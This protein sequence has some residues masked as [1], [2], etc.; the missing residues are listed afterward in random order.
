[1][2]N[3]MI[4]RR[5]SFPR[6]GLATFLITGGVVGFGIVLAQGGMTARVA[7]FLLAVGVLL[8][9]LWQFRARAA[10]RLQATWDAYAEREIARAERRKTP[11][12]IW[13]SPPRK[14]ELR[15]HRASRTGPSVA[16]EVH[17]S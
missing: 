4:G 14:A 12:N 11:A 9:I 8:G 2:E 17:E 16:N 1:V 13:V 3:N 10:R 15:S 5:N 7:A 6:L